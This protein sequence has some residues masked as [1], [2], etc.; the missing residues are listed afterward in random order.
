MHLDAPNGGLRGSTP[1][2]AKKAARKTA[3]PPLPEVRQCTDPDS[4]WYG[5]S[6]LRSA[7]NTRWLVGHPVQGG[8]WADDAFVEGWTPAVL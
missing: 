2:V 1:T 3:P 5:S 7:D 8:M 4:V 6:A